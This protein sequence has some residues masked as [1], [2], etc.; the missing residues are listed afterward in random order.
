MNSGFNMH[1]VR[2]CLTGLFFLLFFWKF[3]T[4]E[5]G[6]KKTQSPTPALGQT[7]TQR[8]HGLCG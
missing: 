2:L 5:A 3:D 7:E 8:A 6:V 4:E 1:C